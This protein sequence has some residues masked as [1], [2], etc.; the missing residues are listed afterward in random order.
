MSLAER[1]PRAGR[2]R[3]PNIESRAIHAAQRVYGRVGLAGFTFDAVAAEAGVGKPALYRRWD[4][5]ED[6]LRS[7][8]LAYSLVPDEQTY[9]DLR[10]QLV[11]IAHASLTL[12]LSDEGL[13]AM[14]IFVDQR[15]R[16]DLFAEQQRH[17]HEVVHAATTGMV[18]RA[19]ERGEVA[20]DTDPNTVIELLIGAVFMHAAMRSESLDEARAG[21][22]AYSE[23]IA[24]LVLKAIDFVQPTVDLRLK[25]NFS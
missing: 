21:A 5:L 10:S 25:V 19:I 15:I 14:R 1:H 16:P 17:I 2:P 3:D 12:L 18:A 20:T 7:A 4:S 9:T 8:L 13:F 6:L 24:D 22:R 11:E 23:T